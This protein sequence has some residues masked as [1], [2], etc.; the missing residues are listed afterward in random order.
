VGAHL[1]GMETEV[2]G[3]SPDDP[4]AGIEAEVAK[5][6]RGVTELLELDDGEI[7]QVPR[8]LDQFVGPGYGLDSA[9]SMAAI[10]LL[11]RV[12]GILLDPVY[13]AKAMVALLAWINDGRLTE[14]DSVL[15]WHTGGQ[16]AFF[17]MD[18]TQVS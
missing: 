5:I 17:G 2:I 9:E 11:A 3:V 18:G 13:T 15:F 1:A 16:L 7:G 12:E 4:S 8:V 14:R 6:A 10:K